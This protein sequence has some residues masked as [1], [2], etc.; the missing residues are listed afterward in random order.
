[1]SIEIDNI[2]RYVESYGFELFA[3]KDLLSKEVKYFV[4]NGKRSVVEVDI[5]NRK[6]IESVCK[7]LR[8]REK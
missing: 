3:F 4:S 8:R 7:M 5:C 2:K 1:M 6:K